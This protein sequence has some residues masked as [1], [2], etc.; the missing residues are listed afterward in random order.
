MKKTLKKNILALLFSVFRLKRPKRYSK[1]VVTLFLLLCSITIHLYS[2]AIW[3]DDSFGQNGITRFSKGSDITCMDFD[4]HG[5]IISAGYSNLFDGSDY[6]YS[7]LL[8]R[9]NADGIIDE[10]FGNNGIVELTGYEGVTPMALKIGNDNKIRLIGLKEID[11]GSEII[12]FQ[13]KEDGSID[14]NFGDSEHTI[15]IFIRGGVYSLNCDDDDFILIAGYQHIVKYSYHGE[16]DESFGEK[17]KVNFTDLIQPTCLKVLKD[18]SIIVAGTYLYYYFNPGHYERC[19][20]TICK[21]THSGEIY[22]DFAED[23]LWHRNMAE[24][25]FWDVSTIFGIFEDSDGNI[26]LT[27]PQKFP[28]DFMGPGYD[29]KTFVIKFTP[30]GKPDSSFGEEGFY[31]FNLYMITQPIIQIGDKYIAGGQVEANQIRIINNDGTVS[32]EIYPCPLYVYCMKL[33]GTNQIILGGSSN[34]N[35]ALV[36]I[37]VD[38]ET[39]VKFIDNRSEDPVIFPNPAKDILYF[40]RETAFEILDLQGRVMLKSTTPVKSAGIGNLKTGIYFVRLGNRV[41]KLIKE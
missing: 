19:N 33:Q 21:I 8:A 29:T 28:R 38:T 40:S 30:E 11:Q 34:N 16:I 1:K 9:T 3:L 25:F 32:N 35:F 18:R 14:E 22:V 26:L 27:G 20:I 31:F 4:T 37:V 7:L 39:S 23:G 12:I 6:N 17:G 24:D 2:Q 5:N 36:R 15:H 13:F 41:H 10:S